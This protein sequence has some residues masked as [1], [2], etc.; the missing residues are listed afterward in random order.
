METFQ[1]LNILS[2]KGKLDNFQILEY[3]RKMKP[4]DLK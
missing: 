2:S 4:V 3:R 1:T